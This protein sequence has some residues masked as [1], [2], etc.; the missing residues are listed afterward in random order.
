MQ[1]PSALLRASIPAFAAALCASGLS[2][3]ELAELREL[4]KEGAL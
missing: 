1:Q 2:A 3:E 4:L